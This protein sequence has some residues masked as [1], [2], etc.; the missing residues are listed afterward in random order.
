MGEIQIRAKKHIYLEETE[1]VTANSGKNQI[2]KKLSAHQE[3]S[4]MKEA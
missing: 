2:E 4:P 1:K 3:E